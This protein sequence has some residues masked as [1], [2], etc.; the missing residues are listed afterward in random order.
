[1]GVA[2]RD[3]RIITAAQFGITFCMN[4][5]MV[6]LPFYLAE[7]SPLGPAA[8]LRWTGL[9]L[10]SAPAMAAFSSPWWGALTRRV[11]PKYIFERG[12]LSHFTIVILMAFVNNIYLF[13]VLRVIQGLLGGISTI[14]LII[15][16][17]LSPAEQR[18]KNMGL[19]QSAHTLGQIAGPPV[20]SLAAAYLGYHTAFFLASAM[21]L[22]TLLLSHWLLH[23]VPLQP[24]PSEADRTPR[25]HF[26]AAWLLGFTVTVQ[27]VFLPSILPQILQGFAIPS[28][29]AVAVAGL[30]VMAYGATSVAGS[31]ALSRRAGE[32]GMRR[33]ILVTVLGGSL[34]QILLILP[35]TLAGFTVVRMLQ[36]AM[37]AAVFPLIIAGSAERG[38]G[39]AIG[40]VNTCRF[41][42]NA[43]GP[44]LATFILA[45][46]SLL[47]LYVVI[48]LSTL[49]AL[50]AF[51]RAT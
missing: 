36:C 24:A 39:T 14:G 30:V 32:W 20:G 33:T 21:I 43:L 23:P 2:S 10:G 16:S 28:Q 27:L 40:F 51:L 5:V 37:V 25:R 19:Y 50:V 26:L 17:A 8:T 47:V 6:F 34:L 4:F 22:I 31:Y 38:S 35:P 49:V 46:S 48:S 9:I 7:I 12:L 29:E 44:I 1:M 18:A 42:G 13:F 41:T 15:V 11:S 45:E 3:I